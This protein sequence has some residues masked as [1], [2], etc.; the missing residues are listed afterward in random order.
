MKRLTIVSL[1][2]VFMISTTSLMAQ[3]RQFGGRGM[4]CQQA[5]ILD[6]TE[7]QQLQF[8]KLRLAH[9]KAMIPL[10][11]QLQALRSDYRLM[12]IDENASKGDLE[13]QLDKIAGV[14]KDMGLQR[15]EHQRQLRA[16]LTDAQK[17]K[18]DAHILSKKRGFRDG[19]MNRPRPN[20]PYRGQGRMQMQ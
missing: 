9:Q 14:R 7:E 10:R 6:L 16:L 12:I 19:R 1:V 11:E 8:D 3:P 20:R 17:V 13:K 15:A 5:N 4:H 2:L 18:F